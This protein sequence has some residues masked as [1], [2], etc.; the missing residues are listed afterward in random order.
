MVTFTTD[1]AFL[2]DN[3]TRYLLGTVTAD[4]SR[5]PR[6]Q[7]TPSDILAE[8]PPERATRREARDDA[9]LFALIARQE[10]S[11]DS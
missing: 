7:F 6:F 1:A 8:L 2:T 10:L 4:A 11:L 5:P 3:G 9:R